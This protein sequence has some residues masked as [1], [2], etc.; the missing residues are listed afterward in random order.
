MITN[1]FPPSIGGVQTHVY[2]LSK[3]IVDLGHKVNVVTRRKDKSLPARETIA[4]INV[5]RIPL[6]NSHLLY[7]WQLKNYIKKLDRESKV[8]V[9]H[10]HGMR[11]LKGCSNLGIPVIFTN[12]TSSFLKRAAQNQK[13]LK[14]MA[15]Q[16]KAVDWVLA[17][18]QEL[19][20]ATKKTG[21]EGPIKFISNGVD[22]QKFSPGHSDLRDRLGIPKDAF[23]AVL[24]RRL[25]QKNGVL[26]LA[27]AIANLGHPS[28]H[29]VVAGDGSDRMEFESIISRAGLD[30]NVHM[31][32]GVANSKM[33]DIYRACDVA[34]LPSL[35]EATS[36]AGLEAMACG[37]PLIGT[38]VGGIPVI[39]E[40]RKNGLLVEPKSPEQLANALDEMIK[41]AAES[42]VMGD[43]SRKRAVEEFSWHSI[44]IE[45]IKVYNS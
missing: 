8:D 6:S 16:L 37:L 21:Y 19:V 39:L 31:L 11:P 9:L 32:G 20:D 44:A 40:D 22:T 26:F 5:H 30:D 14:K 12:H 34:V 4:G 23:V 38:N 28:L 13:V 25:Y 15:A 17:P 24:A 27:Q 33:P 42:K 7:D 18:S 41:N 35:M 10:V 3:A 36:I 43:H 45:T 1:E 29:L 2:E